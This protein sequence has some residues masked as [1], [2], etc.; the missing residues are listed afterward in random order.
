MNTILPIILKWIWD[1]LAERIRTY[2][3]SSEDGQSYCSKTESYCSTVPLNED[4]AK[5]VLGKLS[6][7]SIF[8]CRDHKSKDERNATSQDILCYNPFVSL[9]ETRKI[10]EKEDVER[11]IH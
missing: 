9:V 4:P 7:C 10:E 8:A 6:A 3:Q 1:H 2:V 11:S 5:W